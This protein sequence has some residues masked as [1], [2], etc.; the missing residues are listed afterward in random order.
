M[1]E[2]TDLPPEII[3]FAV[4]QGQRPT[5]EC[6]ICGKPFGRGEG[7]VRRCPQ[8]FIHCQ[9]CRV[10]FDN[11][12]RQEQQKDAQRTELAAGEVPGQLP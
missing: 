1:R 11:H 5:A 8:D 2:V 9:M 3:D 12:R 10:M 6:V 4:L 7:F